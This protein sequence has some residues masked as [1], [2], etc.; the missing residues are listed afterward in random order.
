MKTILVPTDFSDA[1][2][3]AIDYAAHLAKAVHAKLI[4]F[5]AYHLPVVVT[6]TPIPVP[7]KEIE[8][9][10]LRDLGEIKKSL[11]VQYGEELQVECE[12]RLGFALDEIIT[13]SD[14]CHPDLIVMGMQ[15]AGFL[16]EKIIGSITSS[17]IK[18][19]K[20]PVLAIDKQVEFKPVQK[21]VL[22]CDYNRANNS[23]VLKPLREFAQLFGAH[24]YILN[25]VP[26]S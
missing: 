10:S 3:N 1:A 11:S 26:D 6:E 21:I 14:E 5:H 8:E 18:K 22:A 15:G 23:A 4:L 20:Y 24:V 13:Y 7:V 2:R 19:S 12:C 17:L 25:V 9:S 16:T